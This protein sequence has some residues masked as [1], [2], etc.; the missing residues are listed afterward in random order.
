M[1]TDEPRHYG[2]I[3]LNTAT[4]DVLKALPWPMQFPT[5]PSDRDKFILDVAPEFIL[6]YRDMRQVNLGNTNASVDA[7]ITFGQIGAACNALNYGNRAVATGITGLRANSQFK[8]YLTPSEVAIPLADL[9]KIIN[10]NGQA[11]PVVSAGFTAPTFAAEDGTTLAETSYFKHYFYFA[12][13]TYVSYPLYRNF[14][15]RPISDLVTVR[16]DTFTANIYVECAT[17]RVSA[18]ARPGGTWPSSTEATAARPPTDRRS[19]CSAK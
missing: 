1:R 13:S 16:S 8:G 2:K 9:S 3:N 18:F 17:P 12:G 5:A 10:L 11:F 15:Y 4:Y 14:L 7:P 19:L 6:A